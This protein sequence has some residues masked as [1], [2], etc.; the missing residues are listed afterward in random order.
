MSE[1]ANE[2]IKKKIA[3]LASTGLNIKSKM[4]SIYLRIYKKIN[5]NDQRWIISFEKTFTRVWIKE[6]RQELLHRLS[7]GREKKRED[8]EPSAEGWGSMAVRRSA[9]YP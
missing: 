6:A 2:N 1:I 3:F 8:L 5:N 4:E 9:E 7:K